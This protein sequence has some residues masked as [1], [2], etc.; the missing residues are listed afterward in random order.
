MQTKNNEVKNKFSVFYKNNNTQ[1]K[2]GD[3]SINY[4][5]G[6]AILLQKYDSVQQTNLSGLVNTSNEIVWDRN[7]RQN[8]IKNASEPYVETRIFSQTMVNN[9]GDI[10]LIFPKIFNN[11]VIDLIVAELHDEETQ[12]HFYILDKNSILYQSS[13]QLFQERFENTFLKKNAKSANG[14]FDCGYGTL[15]PCNLD[16][17]IIVGGGDSG[18]G[19]C[20]WGGG[21]G[22]EIGGGGCP[23][24]DMC[25]APDS[26]G[27]GGGDPTNE[28]PC[29]KTKKENEKNKEVLNNSKIKPKIDEMTKTVA[30][31]KVEKGF[32]FGVKSNGDYTAASVQTGTSSHVNLP[33][34]SPTGAE[35]TITGSA[36]THPSHGFD[37]FSPADFY[38]FANSY[39]ANNSFRTV[40]VYGSNGVVYSLTITNP[41]QLKNFMSNYPKNDY[42]D[43]NTNGWIKSSS[44]G[45][46][47]KDAFDN[48]YGFQNLSSDLAYALANAYAL[49]KHNAGIAISKQDA[50]GNFNTLFVNEKDS[51]YN[52]TTD[53]NL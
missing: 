46:D 5:K 22:G 33:S 7:L 36:H 27:G 30:T 10:R 3:L 50:N 8:F 26:G 40:F 29:D 21:N 14:G 47:F 32:S 38:G 31:D 6:F 39:T 13:I 43:T 12:V 25:V 34:T 53:C 52:Q 18:G 19:F 37:S 49:A 16:G 51:T 44:I 41:D 42:F 23:K 28:T 45:I 20:C 4:P 2:G 48:F 15:P 9:K 35:Y 11:Q 17:P 1:A 24:Y